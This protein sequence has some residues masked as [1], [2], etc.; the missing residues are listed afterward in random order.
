MA[1][2]ALLCLIF[3]GLLVVSPG[4]L[5]KGVEPVEQAIS[6]LVRGAQLGDKIGIEVVRLHDGARLYQKHAERPLNPASNQKLL[7]AAAALWNLGPTFRASTRVEGILQNGKMA[8]LILRAAGDPSLGYRTLFAL[9][10]ALRLRGVD[11]VEQIVI[12]DSYFDREM[13]PPAFDQQPNETAAFRAPIAA[14]SVDRNSYVV[15]VGPGTDVGAQGRVRVLA[16]HYVGVDNK[17]ITKASG[18]PKVQIDHK[19]TD[20][21]HLQVKVRGQVPMTTRTLYYRRRVPDPR[22]YAAS[23]WVRALRQAGVRGTLNVVYA[24]VPERLPVLADMP[25]GELSGL[26]Y[27]LGKWSDNFTAEMLVKIMGAEEQSPGT[28]AR[29][30][31]VLRKELAAHGV[32]VEGLVMVNGSG[33]FNGN[34]V[35]PHHITQTLVAA[36]QDPGIRAEYLSQLAVGGADG[37]L[38]SRLKNLPR[39]RMVRAKT[40][41]L[42]DVIALSG[43]VLGEPDRSVAFSF[44][45]NGIAGKQA[46]ARD[47]VDK[48]VTALAEY[49]TQAQPTAN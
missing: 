4:A 21:G 34:R 33:L 36:Y 9:A 40:G 43:Y 46:E 37:T 28:S 1:H 18:P 32:E 44:L 8:R 23:L 48:I 17:T 3:L 16:D 31:E 45:A 12:D 19:S 26:L 24:T 7:T 38:Q 14:F 30:I 39:A 11:E 27:S 47:L 35:S 29:G 5:A 25:S 22:S 6:R 2:R 41:T 42:R 10:Q 13:L 20:D 49:A 15:H